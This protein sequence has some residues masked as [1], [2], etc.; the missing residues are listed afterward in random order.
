MFCIIRGAKAPRTNRISNPER[1]RGLG[2][3]YKTLFLYCSARR[4]FVQ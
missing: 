1:Y 2:N 3:A 4:K